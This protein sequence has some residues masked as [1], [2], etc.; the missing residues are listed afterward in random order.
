MIRRVASERATNKWHELI[1]ERSVPLGVADVMQRLMQRGAEGVRAGHWDSATEDLVHAMTLAASLQEERTRGRALLCLAQIQVMTGN[2]EDA[3]PLV[4]EA[5]KAFASCGDDAELARAEAVRCFVAID[6][7]EAERGGQ[8]LVALHDR[9]KSAGLESNTGIVLGYLG[10][11]SRALG[12]SEEARRYY[13]E[14]LRILK[15][16]DTSRFYS[17]FVMDEAIVDLADGHYA[18][19]SEQFARAEALRFEQS[20]DDAYLRFLIAHYASLTAIAGN[21]A[22]DDLPSMCAPPWDSERTRFLERTRRLA[23]R[24]VRGGATT[25]NLGAYAELRRSCPPFDHA[26]LSLAV[27]ERLAGMS[28]PRRSA[29]IVAHESDYFDLGGCRVSLRGRAG[30]RRLLECLVIHALEQAGVAVPVATLVQAAWPGE[31]MSDKTQ[32]NRVH[33][34]LSTLRALGLRAVLR[35]D[36]TGYW[37]DPEIEVMRVA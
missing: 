23:A 19:A 1:R 20:P 13:Q 4:L 3:A 29:L 21:G 24:L 25:A 26:R 30:P 9:L 31:K 18:R 14:A 12:A 35:G 33:V 10:N 36:A 17:V 8:D 5:K 37:L 34:A 27:C 22:T 28:E 2:I 11:A 16:G 7:G 15:Q 32:K 6:L